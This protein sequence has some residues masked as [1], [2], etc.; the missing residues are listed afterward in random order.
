M[1]NALLGVHF[2]NESYILLSTLGVYVNVSLHKHALIYIYTYTPHALLHIYNEFTTYMT[3]RAEEIFIKN[4]WFLT[5][6]I[7]RFVKL[8]LIW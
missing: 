1:Y 8:D 4:F 3:K 7:N 5:V 6:L 2:L